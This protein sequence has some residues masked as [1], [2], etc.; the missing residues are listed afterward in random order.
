VTTRSII[1]VT[2]S[3]DRRCGSAELMRWRNGAERRSPHEERATH[4]FGVT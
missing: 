1:N 3:L 2:W 4:N